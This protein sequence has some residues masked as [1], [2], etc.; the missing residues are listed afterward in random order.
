MLTNDYLKCPILEAYVPVVWQP[1]TRDLCRPTVVKGGGWGVG[2]GV[3]VVELDALCQSSAVC[4]NANSFGASGKPRRH[5]CVGHLCPMAFLTSLSTGLENNACYAPI[6]TRHIGALPTY[7][8]CR[9]EPALKALYRTMS[10]QHAPFGVGWG[11]RRGHGQHLAKLPMLRKYNIIVRPLAAV[12][13]Q[14]HLKLFRGE[15]VVWSNGKSFVIM[16]Y[17]QL[18]V[19]TEVV[20]VA[21]GRQRTSP[22]GAQAQGQ[23]VLAHG[24]HV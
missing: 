16:L 20:S 13:L 1:G 18:N 10:S 6:C 11:V 12:F 9:R 7:A 8:I 23:L 2:G 17:C 14:C 21:Q 5:M 15:R 3:R 24:I 22:V 4:V 19:E